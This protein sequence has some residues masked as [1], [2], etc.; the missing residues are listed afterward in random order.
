MKKTLMIFLV[1]LLLLQMLFATETVTKDTVLKFAANKTTAGTTSEG[2]SSVTFTVTP[3]NNSWDF[4]SRLGNSS[5]SLFTWKMT[6]SYTGKVTV[7][8]EVNGPLTNTVDSTNTVDYTMNISVDS[9]YMKNKK[10][11]NNQRIKLEYKGTS[12]W[13][14]FYDDVKSYRLE[15]Q[16]ENVTV[17]NNS[18]S[19][20]ISLDSSSLSLSKEINF[21]VRA[22]K[23]YVDYASEFASNGFIERNGTGTISFRENFNV[24]AVSPGKYAAKLTITIKTE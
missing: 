9:V 13:L 6:G 14:G 11:T 8:F 24:D 4:T 7:G 5:I 23:N 15:N 17:T 22:M 20:Q 21:Y 16:L 3:T 2:S 10:L 19:F 12:E 1:T 18:N